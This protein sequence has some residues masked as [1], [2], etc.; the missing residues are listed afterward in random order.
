M[1]YT[2]LSSILFEAYLPPICSIHHRDIR[3]FHCNKGLNFQAKRS[4][5]YV[6]KLHKLCTIYSTILH[7]TLVRSL[8]NTARDTQRVLN[9]LWPSFLEVVSFGPMAPPSL[10]KLDCN[11]Y[12]NI[13]GWKITY[14]L[15]YIWYTVGGEGDRRRLKRQVARD[16][17]S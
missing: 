10:N 9:D 3:K 7:G 5:Q 2:Y 8:I 4:K 1:S 17:P 12:G 13:F 6:F 15:F 16:V 14:F 11:V